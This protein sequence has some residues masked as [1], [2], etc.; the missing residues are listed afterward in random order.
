VTSKNSKTDDLL[1]NNPVTEP[2]L[3]SDYLEFCRKRSIS[4]RKCNVSWINIFFRSMPVKPG[5]KLLLQVLKK[6]GEHHEKQVIVLYS[7]FI[8]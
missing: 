1:I 8:L 5:P 6:I 4:D 7:C 2:S 3:F